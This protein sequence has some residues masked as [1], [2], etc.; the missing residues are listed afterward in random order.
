MVR[1][2]QYSPLWRQM[3]VKIINTKYIIL[4]SNKQHSQLTIKKIWG[5]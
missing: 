4:G 1:L 5:E 2:L 3:V